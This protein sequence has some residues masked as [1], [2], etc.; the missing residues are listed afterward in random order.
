MKSETVTHANI[1]Y[2]DILA[3]LISYCFK[4]RNENDSV[5]YRN[6]VETL[7]LASKLTFKDLITDISDYQ[8]NTLPTPKKIDDLVETTGNTRNTVVI[9][10]YDEFLLFIRERLE[11]AGLLMYTREMWIGGELL[12]D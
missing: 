2:Q 10:V 4:V 8:Q 6:S 5:T 11:K 1:A 9:Q 12:H 7:A 3:S